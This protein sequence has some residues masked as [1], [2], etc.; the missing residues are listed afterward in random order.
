MG[1]LDELKGDRSRYEALGE[2]TKHKDCLLREGVEVEIQ[3]C[4]QGP[5]RRD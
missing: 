1:K 5:G 4:L 3:P 2:V